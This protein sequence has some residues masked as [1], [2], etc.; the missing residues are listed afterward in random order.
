MSVAFRRE[1][2]EEHLEPKFA[3]PIPPGPNLVTAR[4]KALIDATVLASEAAVAAAADEAAKASAKRALS[5]WQ[6]RQ[7]TAE[8]PPPPEGEHV[9][10][11]TTV[12]FTLNGK[13][14]TLTLVG[15]DEADAV[16]GLIGFTAPLAR[17]MM[18]SEVGDILPFGGQADAIEIRAISPAV[19][20]PAQSSP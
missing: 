16:L 4:G 14:R 15:V 5:Y 17:A 3:I 20:L 13:P 2:D 18:G 1:S 19:A 10:F 7:V 12:C 6:V 9:E 8:I 11:G